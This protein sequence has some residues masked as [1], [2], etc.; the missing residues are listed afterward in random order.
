M[1][2]A[3]TTADPKLSLFLLFTAPISFCEQSRAARSLEGER[4]SDDSRS[5]SNGHSLP[6]DARVPAEPPVQSPGK[7]RGDGDGG[8]SHSVS[9][10]C[11]LLQ[12]LAHLLGQQQVFACLTLPSCPHAVP[13]SRINNTCSLKQMPLSIHRVTLPSRR[14]TR[15]SGH[16][17]FIPWT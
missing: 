1:L 8:D 2:L 17:S 6:G 12:P 7:H 13:S 16:Q 10:A 14:E 15:A 9:P 11:L 4:G 3:G 5:H